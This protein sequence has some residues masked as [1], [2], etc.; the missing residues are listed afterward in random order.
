MTELLVDWCSYEAAKYAVM[1][2]HY[3][4]SMPT[5]PRLTIGAWEDGVFIG[6][7]IFSRGSN[8]NMLKPYDLEITEGCEL[9][10]IALRS[11]TKHQ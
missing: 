11:A 3:S 10:R 1:H 4:R 6:V 2:W 7:V 9:T 8:N 5:P